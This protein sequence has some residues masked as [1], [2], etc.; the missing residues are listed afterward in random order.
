LIGDNRQYHVIIP[1]FPRKRES[2][3]YVE[4]PEFRFRGNLSSTLAQ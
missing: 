3:D 1:S 4:K 2:R